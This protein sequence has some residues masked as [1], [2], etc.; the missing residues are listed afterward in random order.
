MGETDADHHVETFAFKAD[1]V[2]I[3]S[4]VNAAWSIYTRADAIGGT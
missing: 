4:S 3:I 1:F 2:Q